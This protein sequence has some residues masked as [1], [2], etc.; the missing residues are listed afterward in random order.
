MN[1]WLPALA[2]L[3]HSCREKKQP[4]KFIIK[5]IVRSGY[6]LSGRTKTELWFD[7]ALQTLPA[8]GSGCT[9]TARGLS[10]PACNV[11]W[12]RCRDE[13]SPRRAP[14]GHPADH[15]AEFSVRRLR[16]DTAMFVA[17][18]LWTNKHV[19]QPSILVGPRC[20]YI[21]KQLHALQIKAVFRETWLSTEGAKYPL[22]SWWI[23]P[24]GAASKYPPHLFTEICYPIAAFMV[25]CD[26]RTELQTP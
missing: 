10:E 2:L 25:K 1:T 5:N 15:G 16:S 12:E 14:G 13:P 21:W 24:G 19:L 9:C 17:L 11:L 8:R 22:L 6:S 4:A 20:I 23:L 26:I 7:R 3:G 18:P